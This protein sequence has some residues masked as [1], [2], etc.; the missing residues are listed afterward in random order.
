MIRDKELKGIQYSLM[1]LSVELRKVKE[2][3]EIKED[4]YQYYSLLLKLKENKDFLKTV[5]S[6][7]SY[8]EILQYTAFYMQND[9]KLIQGNQTLPCVLYHMDRT[10]GLSNEVKVQL[11]FEKGSDLKADRT[12]L[13]DDQLSG[14]GI[15]GFTIKSID[16]ENYEN[17]L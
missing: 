3:T 14:N 1:Y 8:D 17:N 12:I 11:V 2:G 7:R 13:F 16:I 4:G 10:Y 5:A 9:F 6:G 15:V